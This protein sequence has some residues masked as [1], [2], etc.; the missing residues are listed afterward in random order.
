MRL[1]VHNAE[2]ELY[3]LPATT[4]PSEVMVASLLVDSFLSR[5][6]GLLPTTVTEEMDTPTGG[7]V[8]AT[9]L[10]LVSVALAYSGSAY[11]PTWVSLEIDKF[12]ADLASGVIHFSGVPQMS[13]LRMIQSVGWS[14][15]S[16]PSAIKL[17][18]SNLVRERQGASDMLPSWKRARAGDVEI[19]RWS[20]NAV[21]AETATLLAPYRRIT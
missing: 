12:E 1:Y 15:D 20:Q 13:R 8:V 9:R 2:Y 5:P 18:T 16:I 10:P 3:G 19:E 14:Y 4:T 17:A 6:E 21:D 11:N 7:Y